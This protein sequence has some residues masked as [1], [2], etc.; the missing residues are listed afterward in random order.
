MVKISKVLKLRL[1]RI[2]RATLPIIIAAFFA[3]MHKIVAQKR[4]K[5]LT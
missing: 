5:S 3:L 2:R 1:W 4:R